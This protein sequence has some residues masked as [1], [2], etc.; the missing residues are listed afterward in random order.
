MNQHTAHDEAVVRAF[1][2]PARRGRWL[3]ALADPT[4][5]PAFLDR[6]NHCPDLDPRFA[7]AVPRG[8]DV[9][10]LLRSRGAPL[11]CYVLSATEA[12]DCRELPLGEAVAAVEAGG[13]GTIV[14]CLPGRLAYFYDEC[15][16]R[17]LLL[18]RAV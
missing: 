10:D 12:L 18:E 16:E 8:A 11:T 13:W 5:R 15:G 6:L 4:R 17:R 9:A 14:S 3:E 7:V 2:T 1:I